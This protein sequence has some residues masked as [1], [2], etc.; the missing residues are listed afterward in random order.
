VI[1]AVLGVIVALDRPR[2]A[3][4]DDRRLVP[5]M[6]PTRVSSIEA[7]GVTVVKSGD[8]W[9]VVE[10]TAGPADDAAIADLLG[11]LA[12][13]R[14]ERTPSGGAGAAM[15]DAI[16]IDRTTI[17]F[18]GEVAGAQQ[19]WA[20]VDDG[21]PRLVPSWVAHAVRRD[22]ASLR[23]TQLV[24]ARPDEITGLEIHGPGVELVTSGATLVGVGRIDRAALDRVGAALA[25]LRAIAFPS[26]PPPAPVAGAIT[27]RVIGAT[28]TDELV[29][30]GP[31]PSG[32]VLLDGT[33]GTVCVDR[34]ALE[35]VLDAARAAQTAIDRAP[36]LPKPIA[37]MTWLTGARASVTASGGGFRLATG[38]ADDDAVHAAMAA[39]RAPAAAVEP[40]PAKAAITPVLDVK[41]ADGSVDHLD[42]VGAALRRNGE[43]FVLRVGDDALRAASLQVDDLR[44][45][46]L[47]VEEP[48]ALNAIEVVAG[49]AR[50]R[51]QRG[52]VIG[53]WSGDL[54][55]A[56]VLAATETI[57]HLRAARFA[58]D[59]AL[60]PTRAT[61]T[62]TFDAPPIAGGTPTTHTIELADHCAARV[63]HVPVILDDARCAALTALTH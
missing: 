55:G 54:D 3:I 56:A 33:S 2:G 21:P 23:R 43:P 5:G 34:A 46:A 14:W 22:A 52:T 60:G 40:V 7:A 32:G 12:A 24:R 17:H 53:D 48:S 51:A 37:T 50:R 25:A 45:R 42:R 4:A 30:H 15:K 47:I 58:T 29:E 1:A 62:A 9:K 36:L 16:T 41:Y 38:P 44:D 28:A 63:D 31:C 27:I 57:A 8:A 6:D 39:L 13:A 20:Q 59:G 26:A 11:A 49:K 35:A 10:P 19:T 18:G 61:I